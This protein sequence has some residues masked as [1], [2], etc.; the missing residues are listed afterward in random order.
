MRVTTYQVC[1]LF[2]GMRMEG[3]RAK[4]AAAAANEYRRLHELPSGTMVDVYDH[5]RERWVAYQ[6]T[7]RGVLWAGGSEEIRG[8]AKA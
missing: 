7:A 2:T 4:T 3:M 5:V 6:A 1:M 8:R